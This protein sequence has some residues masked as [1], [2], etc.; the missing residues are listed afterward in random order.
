MRFAHNICSN[1]GIVSSGRA[2]IS[3]FCIHSYYMPRAIC[4]NRH[5]HRHCCCVLYFRL[6]VLLFARYLFL[7]IRFTFSANKMNSPVCLFFVCRILLLNRNASRRFF[8]QIDVD[9]L[10]S[11]CYALRIGLMGKTCAIDNKRI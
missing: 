5:H 10:L 7:F 11:I 3:H 6:I 1:L 4:K 9:F 8:V 2:N